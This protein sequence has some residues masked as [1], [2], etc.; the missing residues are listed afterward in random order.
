MH[1]TG[2][3][4]HVIAQGLQK[5]TKMAPTD[6]YEEKLIKETEVTTPPPF[7]IEKGAQHQQPVIAQVHRISPMFA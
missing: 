7:D 2:E 1:F 3:A 6:V 4:A 5:G